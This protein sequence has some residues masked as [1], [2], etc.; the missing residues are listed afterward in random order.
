DELRVRLLVHL[1]RNIELHSHAV[2]RLPGLNVTAKALQRRINRQ[3][4]WALMVLDVDHLDVYTEVYGY[5]P[6]NQVLK[7]LA[8]MIQQV[9]MVSDLISQTEENTY[10][11][12]T[13]PEKAEK[14]AAILCRQFENA[15]PNFYS[16]K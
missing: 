16:E 3:E 15:S 2:T 5:L 7:T 6:S 14:M 8:A 9:L 10:V 11:I 13:Q 12:L 4:P 1:R